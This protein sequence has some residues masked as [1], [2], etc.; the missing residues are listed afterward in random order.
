MIERPLG[1]SFFSVRPKSKKTKIRFSFIGNLTLTKG[2]DILLDAFVRI[3]NDSTELHIH[4]ANHSSIPML[5]D[6]EGLQSNNIFYHGPYTP[7]SLSSIL[8]ETDVGIVP[9]RSDNFPTVVREFFHAG[10]PVVGSDAGGV[11]ELVIQDI[12]GRIFPSQDT[13]ALKFELE[14]LIQAPELIETYTTNLRPQFNIETDASELWT[15]TER[16]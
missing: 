3:E 12:N 4:G 11:P 13:D 15:S 8:S 9:S 5:E 14:R 7:E 1:L 10:I 16:L 2:I 6:P